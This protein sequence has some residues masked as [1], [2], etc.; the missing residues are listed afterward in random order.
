MMSDPEMSKIPDPIKTAQQEK[1]EKL[2]EQQEEIE[3]EEQRAQPSQSG[4][5]QAQAKTTEEK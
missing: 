1:E 4:E 2:A 3:K 5:I